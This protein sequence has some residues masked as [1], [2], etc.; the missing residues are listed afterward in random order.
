[1]K[2]DISEKIN[3]DT[4]QASVSDIGQL[5]SEQEI[6][7]IKFLVHGLPASARDKFK[8]LKK[9]GVIRKNM[10]QFFVDAFLSELKKA[11]R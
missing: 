1:M 6:K 10:S 8:E 5:S 7:L 3:T 4:N 2:R 11:E 9:R